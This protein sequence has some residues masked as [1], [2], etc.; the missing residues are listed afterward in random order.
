V[1]T[2]AISWRASFGLQVI[3]VAWIILLAR[4]I[5]DPAEAE[6]GATTAKPSFDLAG[7][8][9]SATG[10]F[11]VV[12]GLLQARTYGFG[13][14]RADFTIG[15]TVVIPK[16][17]ISPVWIFVAIGALFLLWFFLYTRSAE[18]KGRDVLLHL[19]M[20][21]NKVSNLGLGT[22]T[23]QWLILQ[24]A[25]FTVSVYLQE[26]NHYSAVKTGLVLTPGTIGILV[27]SAAADRFARRHPQRW[28]I[29]AGFFTTAIGMLLLLLLV[30]AEAGIWRWVPGLLLFGIGVGTMLTSSVNV[31]QS[32]FPE[33]DQGEISGLS[34]SVSNLG[35]SLGTALVGAALVASARPAGQP[36]GIAMTMMLVF[37]LIGLT[38][39]VFIPRRAAGTEQPAESATAGAI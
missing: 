16:G 38:L 14:S 19:R 24:G 20:F 7:A 22:Q 26:V 27:A 10:L 17:S 37:A 21:R 3:V 4:K 2:S 31:V 18:K 39:G 36:F 1:V 30:R 25:F 34:R 8:V 15:S 5:T 9:L 6:A 33:S 32:S 11:F 28:L 12:L 29:I 35:S 23:I 13:A